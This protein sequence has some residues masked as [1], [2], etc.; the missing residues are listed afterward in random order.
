M[1]DFELSA[2]DTVK[3]EAKALQHDDLSSSPSF[4]LPSRISLPG[5]FHHH[6]S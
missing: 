5:P 1:P 6:V 2:K 3:K 4:P